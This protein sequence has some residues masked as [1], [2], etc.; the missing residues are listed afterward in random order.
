MPE[1]TG[2]YGKNLLQIYIKKIVKYA[3]NLFYYVTNFIMWQTA[4]FKK[5]KK[6]K[7]MSLLNT[8]YKPRKCAASM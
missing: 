3:I 5:L 1:L 6:F 7:C 2:I 4:K 8:Q